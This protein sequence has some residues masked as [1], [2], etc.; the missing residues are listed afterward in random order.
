MG[1]VRRLPDGST[2]I[3]E[4]RIFVIRGQRAMLGTDLAELYRVSAKVFN[5]AVRRNPQ[6]FPKDFMLQLTK[7]EAAALR[8]QIVTLENGR[9]RSSKYA[10][11]AFTEHGVAL[12]SAVLNSRRALQMNLLIIRAFVKLREQISL[13]RALATRMERVEITQGRHAS[14]INILAEEIRD[15]RQPKKLPSKTR[16]GFQRATEGSEATL[17]LSRKI[18]RRL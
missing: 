16:I 14:V 7:K 4:S 1:I 12:L 10:P 13:H 5:Q 9:G 6:R 17:V 3:V 2:E 15:L 18:R 8:S 11:L